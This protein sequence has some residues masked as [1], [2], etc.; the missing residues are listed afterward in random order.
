MGN[1]YK[2]MALKSGKEQKKTFGT[3]FLCSRTRKQSV[4]LLCNT[5][6]M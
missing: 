4:Y 1:E 3:Y 6:L 5:F 2:D